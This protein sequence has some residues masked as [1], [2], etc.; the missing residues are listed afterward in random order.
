MH[1]IYGH[2]WA[3]MVYEGYREDFPHQTTFYIDESG[4]GRIPAI[5][6]NPWTGDVAAP[7][8]D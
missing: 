3:K 1:N 5:W 6:I 2:D 8:A 7:G 4:S